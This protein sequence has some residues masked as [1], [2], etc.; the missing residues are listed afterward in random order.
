MGATYEGYN[1]AVQL[2]AELSAL[3]KN[4][5]SPDTLAAA[6]ALDV[7]AQGLTDATGPPAALG[8]MNRDLT[9]LMIAVD[10]SDT[11][12]AA[13]LIDTFAGMCQ[14]AHAALARWS[15]LRTT[16]IPQ[17]NAILVRESLSPLK[18]ANPT[19]QP[20]DCGNLSAQLQ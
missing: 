9:R 11:A 20:P 19:Q 2:R 15:D 10:Q 1:Q 5:K 12:P 8:P 17:L 7:K 3:I 14:D 6:K 4:A 18:V 16:D 13:S